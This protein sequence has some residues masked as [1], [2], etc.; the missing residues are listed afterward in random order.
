MS[1]LITFI[2][3]SV[4]EMKAENA[5]LKDKI[6]KLRDRLIDV[7]SRTM[8]NNLN[9]YNT[10]EAE[11]YQNKENIVSREKDLEAFLK[12]KLNYK[13]EIILETAHRIGRAR[14]GPNGRRTSRPSWQNSC[15]SSKRKK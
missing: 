5:K 9:F 4:Q 1:T 13:D 10:E 3:D 15:R 7:Q 14:I 11:D 6:E 12:D 2:N 8:H